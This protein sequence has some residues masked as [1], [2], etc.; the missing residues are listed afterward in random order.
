MSSQPFEYDVFLSF[1]SRDEGIARPLWEQ[2]SKCGLRVFWSDE[3]LRRKA[4]QD[5]YDLLEQAL[6]NSRHMVLIWSDAAAASRFVKKEY[7]SFD[8]NFS[9]A[10]HRLLIPVLVPGQT[11][12]TLPLFLKG[13]QIFSMDEEKDIGLLAECLGGQYTPANH[14]PE[15]ASP[16][17]PTPSVTQAVLPET[18]TDAHG[19]EFILIQPGTFNMGS[20]KGAK[21]EKSVHPVEITRPFYLGKYPVTQGQ[22]TAVMGK[23][24]S[25][26]QKSDWHPVERVS[27]LDAQAFIEKLNAGE[28]IYRLPTE[29][30]WEYACRAG[31]TSEYYFGDLPELL[32]KHAWYDSNTSRTQPVGELEA[33]AWGLHDMLGNV[34]EWVSDWYSERS[35]SGK[36]IDPTGPSNGQYRVARGGSFQ[37]DA[38][39][40]R[41]AARTHE[42]ETNANVN[43][44]VRLVLEAEVR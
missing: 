40:C 21:D 31:S 29:A 25:L 16:T 23:N 1:S 2:L 10:S 28:R 39:A 34:R 13:R 14:E 30:E 15:L 8:S 32:E 7:R 17:Q 24:P 41:S 44:G 42:F 5:W 43:L 36:A 33:N 9:S 6:A 37:S 35:L 20:D 19:I 11:F 26:F 27:W 12:D 4:G 18:V 3:T 38:S 22:W